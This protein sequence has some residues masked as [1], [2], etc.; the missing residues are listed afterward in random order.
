MGNDFG[1]SYEAVKVVKY[2]PV[3]GL[4]VTQPRLRK[5][6]SNREPREARESIN[7]YVCPSLLRGGDLCIP[8]FR[9]GTVE[10]AA[11]T[12]SRYDLSS[13]AEQRKREQYAKSKNQDPSKSLRSPA[14]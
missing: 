6:G 9:N 4:A 5:Q 11:Q 7:T 14:N 3:G 1:A 12:S 13:Q 8:I 10:N 2:G